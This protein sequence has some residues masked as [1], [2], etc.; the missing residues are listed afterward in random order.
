M[1]L[2]LTQQRKIYRDLPACK[3]KQVKAACSSC[4]MSGDG[5]FSTMLNAVKRVLGSPLAKK[6]GSTVLKEVVIPEA[7]KK[8]ESWKKQK[9][10]GLSLAGMGVKKS[11]A[12]AKKKKGNGISL[13]GMGKKRKKKGNG[14]SLAGNG[15]SLAGTGL[16]LAGTG[17]YEKCGF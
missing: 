7:K 3:K 10:Q 6:I 15:I 9:G 4:S 5:W 13:A 14:L 17:C 1:T 12:A 11:K 2:T 8:F 16:S